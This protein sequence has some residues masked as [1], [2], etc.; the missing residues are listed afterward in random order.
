MRDE[1]SG[2]GLIKYIISISGQTVTH[3][4]R[5]PCFWEEN[6]F[7]ALKKTQNSFLEYNFLL[8]KKLKNFSA[9]YY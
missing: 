3:S 7:L 4:R 9:F 1:D 5:S 8:F 2:L 6:I